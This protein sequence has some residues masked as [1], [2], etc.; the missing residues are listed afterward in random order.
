[1]SAVGWGWGCLLCWTAWQGALLL[2]LLLVGFG[3]W[4]AKVNLSCS[5]L[6]MTNRWAASKPHAL[7]M[8]VGG[9]ERWR[10]WGLCCTG[11]PAAVVLLQLLLVDFA[12]SLKNM[13]AAPPLP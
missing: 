13:Q 10:G 8:A 12:K 7:L 4:H 5:K 3:S 6:F 1:M 9:V 11:C 2:L